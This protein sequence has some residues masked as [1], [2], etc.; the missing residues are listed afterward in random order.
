MKEESS[1]PK[2]SFIKLFDNKRSFFYEIIKEGTYSLVDQLH[3]TRNLK[4]LIPHD[5]VVKT[6]YGKEKH[7][8]ECS[9]NYLDERPLFKVCFGTKFTKEVYSWESSTEAACKY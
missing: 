3:Y 7:L 9:I 6:Q 1:Y 2:S 5:Y 8:V 4:Y